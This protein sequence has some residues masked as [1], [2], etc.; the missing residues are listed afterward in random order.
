MPDGMALRKAEDLLDVGD[1]A[2]I[3]HYSDDLAL[4]G[5]SPDGDKMAIAPDGTGV[6]PFTAS[7]R[8]PTA[9]V[10]VALNGQFQWFQQAN[11]AM[12]QAYRRMGVYN[13]DQ[14]ETSFLFTEVALDMLQGAT[15]SGYTDAQAGLL[16]KSYALAFGSGNNQR[17]LSAEDCGSYGSSNRS[18]AA[19]TTVAATTVNSG[20]GVGKFSAGGV[21]PFEGTGFFVRPKNDAAACVIECTRA[22]GVTIQGDFWVSCRGAMWNGGPINLAN[23][24]GAD[25]CN[26]KRTMRAGDLVN[27]IGG[28]LRTA[29]ASRAFRALT[30]RG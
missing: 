13:S 24:T 20:T 21:F 3:L 18:L 23:Q 5:I 17:F 29:N 11:V 1:R 27:R 6:I 7:W 19:A 28:L 25:A 14:S 30:L 22:H 8:I 9:S 16:L 4:L 15:G 2:S 12:A 26:G 10:P